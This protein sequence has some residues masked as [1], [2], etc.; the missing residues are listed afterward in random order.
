MLIAQD[1]DGERKCDTLDTKR[2]MIL[3]KEY[4]WHHSH[5]FDCYLA[6]LF[7]GGIFHMLSTYSWD[8]LDDVKINGWTG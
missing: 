7:F 2:A 5:D 4:R 1:G 8:T 6:A 3:V